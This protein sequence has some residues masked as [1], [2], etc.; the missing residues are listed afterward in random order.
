MSDAG[1]TYEHSVPLF[2]PM[3]AAMELQKIGLD[4]V[5]KG[6]T[7]LDEAARI[8]APP[9][10]EWATE[11]HVLLDLDTMRLRDF[12]GTGGGVPVLVDAPFAG[13]SSTIADYAPGQSLIETL[14]GAGLGRV[15]C[16]DWKSATPEMRDFDIDKYLAEINVAVDDLGGRVMLVGLCQGGWTSAMYAARFPEKVAALVLAGSPIDTDAGHGPI[17]EL[18][19]R[20]PLSAYQEMVDA[21]EGRMPGRFMLAGWKNMHADEQYFGKFVDLYEH[22]GDRNFMKRTERFESWYENP[23]DL[24]GRYYLQAIDLLFKQNLFAGGK[25]VGLG[26]RLDLGAI[27]CPAF[28]L[29]GKDDDITTREQ[30]FAAERLLGTPRDKI[31]SRL[32]EGGHIGL[33]MGRHTLS[34]VWPEIGRWLGSLG[35]RTGDATDGKGRR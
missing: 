35:A 30:V 27:T 23:I 6:L 5:E 33:F 16:T 18:A 4:A 2:W 21:G 32:V 24:P 26:R 15:L 14:L 25:F 17:R 12:G 10:P 1:T 34:E 20:M 13:H 7:Y 22:I 31:V 8:T 29:A 9:A 11:N 19:H 3:A 28:L